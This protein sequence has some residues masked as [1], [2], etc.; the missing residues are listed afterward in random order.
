VTVARV[1]SELLDAAPDIRDGLVS[2]PISDPSVMPA[3]VRRLDDAGVQVSEL[4]LRKSSLDEVF[5]ALTG[6][7]A[8]EPAADEDNDQELIKEGAAV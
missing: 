3:V 7:R 4:A 2:T 5:F 8:E 1:V 6:H